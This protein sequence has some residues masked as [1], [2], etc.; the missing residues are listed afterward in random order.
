VWGLVVFVAG[1]ADTRQL[2]SLLGSVGVKDA[3][4]VDGGDSLLLGH[5]DEVVVVG[6]L[7]L[8]WKRLLQVW[9]VVFRRRFGDHGSVPR[10]CHHGSR[11]S[12][13]VC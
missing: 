2:A 12:E 6:K 3:V 7:M 5:D 13:A 1:R 9:G 11:A 4:Q 8:P 10:A